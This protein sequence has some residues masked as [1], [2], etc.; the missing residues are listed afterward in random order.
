MTTIA[1]NPTPYIHTESLSRHFMMGDQIVY[2]LD[3][4]DLTILAG[5][6]L[7]VM[8]PSGSGKSTLL[9]LIGGLDR[10]TAGCIRVNG[11]DISQ[12]TETNLDTY[13]KYEIGFVFQSFHLIPTMTALENVM[14]PMLFTNVTAEKRTS[15][16]LALLESVDLADRA[17]HKPTELSGGQQQRVA[18]ARSLANDPPLILADEPTGNLDSHSGTEIMMLLAKLNRQEGR[19]VLVVS[20]DPSIQNYATRLIRLIDGITAQERDDRN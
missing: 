17:F 9:Y 1:G 6:F 4:L 3:R 8:G 18:I 10:P 7:A 19:T 13:R 15:R 16:A 20:H 2:A 14:F 5:E 11:H 12:M